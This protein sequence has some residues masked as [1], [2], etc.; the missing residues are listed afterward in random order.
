[1]PPQQW[2]NLVEALDI[3]AITAIA[4]VMFWKYKNAQERRQKL[5]DDLRENRVRIYTAIL[6]PY[7]TAMTPKIVWERDRRSKRMSSSDAALKEMGATDYIMT[8]MNLALVG[9]DEVVIAHNNLKQHFFKYEDDHEPTQDNTKKTMRLVGD[10]LR[11][12]RRSM[13]NEETK[14][15]NIGMLEWLI[16]DAHVFR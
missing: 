15:D 10:L 9:S 6:K 4:A 2:L 1:M 8:C 13:G 16:T 3:P 11:A 7:I 12:I 5:R 14:I